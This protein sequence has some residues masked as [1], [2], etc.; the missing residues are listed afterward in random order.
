MAHHRSRHCR[1]ERR[2]DRRLFASARMAPGLVG[3][4]HRRDARRRNGLTAA[5]RRSPAWRVYRVISEV[6]IYRAANLLIE[7]RGAD[8]VIEAARMID[9]MLELSDPEGRSVWKRSKSAIEHLQAAPT[10]LH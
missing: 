2:G 6:D 1:R 7:R 3:G 4:Q 9:R 5:A 8:A 10:A